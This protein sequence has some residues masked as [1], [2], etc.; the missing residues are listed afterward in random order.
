MLFG[1]NRLLWKWISVE[2]LL[3]YW[4]IEVG[5]R[6]CLKYLV[7]I[8]LSFWL[9]FFLFGCRVVLMLLVLML[10]LLLMC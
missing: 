7:I 1:L 10:E 3:M 6:F 2:G 8:R 4:F 5:S 9:M